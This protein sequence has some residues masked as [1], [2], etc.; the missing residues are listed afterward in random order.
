MTTPPELTW[1]LKGQYSSGWY[2]FDTYL[3]YDKQSVLIPKF[4]QYSSPFMSRF[5]QTKHWLIL[6]GTNLSRNQKTTRTR[7]SRESGQ[8]WGRMTTAIYAGIFHSV[9]YALLVGGWTN[10]F[11]KYQSKWVHLPQVGVKI[12]NIWNHHLDYHC[13]NF[14]VIFDFL[15]NFSFDYINP[16]DN[17][18]S[19]QNSQ[20]DFCSLP[21]SVPNQRISTSSLAPSCLG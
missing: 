13:I 20:N 16:K 7:R 2:C 11:E 3:Q 15:F 4:H 21:I 5:H 19:N 17:P 18:L 10:P 1:P 12:K 8:A 14:C 6:L 9:Q